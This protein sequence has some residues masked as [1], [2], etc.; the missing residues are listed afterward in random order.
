[1]PS[2]VSVVSDSV[3]SITVKISDVHSR[4]FTVKTS[5][6]TFS[7]LSSGLEAAITD[8]DTIHV[9]LTGS[10]EALAA[11][12]ASDIKAT[13]NLTGL[14]EGTYTLSIQFQLPGAAVWT[15]PIRQP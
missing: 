12:Q 11:A 9:I 7:G 3:V 13:V 4:E 6:I 5:D 8:Q 14:K 15:I 2:D 1:M 10:D